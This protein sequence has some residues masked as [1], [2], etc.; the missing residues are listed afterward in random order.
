MGTFMINNI[1]LFETDIST[2]FIDGM[3]KYKGFSLMI[4]YALREAIQPIAKNKNGTL[5]GEK[6]N[7]GKGINLQTGYLF[8]KNWEIATRFTQIDLKKEITG[9]D[10][11]SQYT[12]GVSKYFSRHKLKVQSD[13]SYATSDNFSTGGILISRLLIDIHF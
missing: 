7:E 2:L 9:K 1:S 12:L 8:K 5:T 3:F 10:V 6:I 11:T 4:E 13:I